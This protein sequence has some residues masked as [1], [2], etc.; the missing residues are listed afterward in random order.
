M[1]KEVKI[2]HLIAQLRF[3]AGRCVAD[4]AIEQSRGQKHD[5]TICVSADVDEHWRT[6]PKIIT[7]LA[8]YGIEVLKIGDF[9]HRR[10]D[11]LHSSAA[12]LRELGA[13]A[14]G[15]FIV[16]AHTAMAAAVGHWARPDSLIATC[17]GWGANR[18]A[19]F[20][21]EDSLAYQLCDSVITYSN[22]WANRLSHDL[23]VD[24]VK[25]V[26]MGLN[27]SR[28][29]SLPKK[30]L[31]ESSP[32]RIVTVCE[33]T[34][35]KGVDILLSAMP[36]VWKEISNAEL[37]I[38]GH[39]DAAEDLRLL[40]RTMD[41]GMK[42]ILFHGNVQDPYFHLNDY[43]L[44]VLASRSDNMPIALLEAM[45][46]RLPIVATAVGGTPDL[47]SAAGCGKVALPES[48]AS[49]AEASIKLLTEDRDRLATMGIN[50]EKYVRDRMDIR[51][52]VS[53]LDAIYCD[54]LQTHRGL[55]P[56][57]DI[58]M[59]AG[60]IPAGRDLWGKQRPFVNHI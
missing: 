12:R 13:N 14:Q 53:A 40:A 10:S 4:T 58:K 44:F 42:R 2:V 55:D 29:P 17:H 46:A 50:G 54:A 47:L 39:G 18:P 9:F 5:V 31:P 43:D 27:L 36:M 35:R 26:L 56:G 59:A 1:G 33:L 41:P 20:D 32:P 34:P 60:L 57:H 15:A 52:T 6:D 37:H 11:K 28:F 16:H 25:V 48:A 51:K 3:G 22:H 38:L 49:L 19:D 8:S 45:L 24:G 21:L 30:R 7:E 23:A